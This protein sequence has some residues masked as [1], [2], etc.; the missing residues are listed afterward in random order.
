ML[1]SESTKFDYAKTTS[2]LATRGSREEGEKAGGGIS[3]GR[4]AP[5]GKATDDP[6]ADSA[7]PRTTKDDCV[8]KPL[9]NDLVVF[10]VLW[11]VNGSP[12]Q[13]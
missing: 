7:P 9:I 3:K 10:K 12:S 13:Y 4:Q 2:P 1:Q 8:A 5:E 6:K 11:H